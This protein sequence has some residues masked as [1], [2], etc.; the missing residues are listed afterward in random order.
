MVYLAEVDFFYKIHLLTTAK[1]NLSVGMS[2]LKILK[3]HGFEHLAVWHDLSH[4]TIKVQKL[5]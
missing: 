4:E 2:N 1:V 5:L 3:S